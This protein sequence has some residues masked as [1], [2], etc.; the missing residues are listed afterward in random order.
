MSE[1]KTSHSNWT[2]DQKKLYWERR[3]KGLHGVARHAI[4]VKSTFDEKPVTIDGVYHPE[5]TFLGYIPISDKRP[6]QSN[7]NYSYQSI[8]ELQRQASAAKQHTPYV[9]VNQSQ[10]AP[11]NGRG[12]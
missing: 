8:K 9:N 10:L 4:V 7:R 2:I 1:H 6:P 12:E 5:G 3:Q 11:S